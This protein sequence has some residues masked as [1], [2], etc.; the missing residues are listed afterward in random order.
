MMKAILVQTADECGPNDGPDYSHGWGLVNTLAALQLVQADASEPGHLR[1]ETLDDGA[2]HTWY[3]SLPATESVRI[4]IAWTDP[5][6]TPPADTLDPPDLM[7][8][9]DLDLRLRNGP[10]PVVYEPW[11]LDPANPAAAATTGDNFRDNVEQVY[12][13]DLPAGDYEVTVSH[14]GTLSGGEQDY[15]LASSVALGD[16]P[17]VVGVAERRA[18]GVALDVA[19]SPNPFVASTAISFSTP[20]AGR[21]RASI[22]DVGGRVVRT[23][24]SAGTA[25]GPRRLDW[26]GRDESGRRLASGVYFVRVEAPGADA[27]EKVV[28]LRAR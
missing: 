21:V 17:P 6:G 19:V 26:D 25:A 10:V 28:L 1:Q 8:V 18:S 22:V 24:E 5:P 12:A 4:S 3:F 11:V 27:I 16:T 15:A 20:Q 14:K 7:L 2:E 13:A 23:L 9:N